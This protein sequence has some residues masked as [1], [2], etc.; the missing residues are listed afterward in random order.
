MRIKVPPLEMRNIRR[1]AGVESSSYLAAYMCTCRKNTIYFD[2]V[3]KVK[4]KVGQIL[5]RSE[6]SGILIVP[7]YIPED[8]QGFT[9]VGVAV[10]NNTSG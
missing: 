9:F 1:A 6:P 2:G 7:S 4:P 10:V 8:A 3:V 5:S